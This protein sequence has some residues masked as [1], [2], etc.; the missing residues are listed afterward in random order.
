MS[1]Q[2]LTGV[3]MDRPASARLDRSNM[4]SRSLNLVYVYALATGAIFTFMC[5]WDGIFMSYTGPATFLGFGLMTAA[6]LPIAFLYAELSTML[7]SAGSALVFNTI[8]LNKHMGFW[9]SWL[10]LLCW[11][12]VPTAG[13]LGILDWLVYQ[14]GFSLTP[15]GRIIICAAALAFWCALS[16]FKNVVA[17]KV[18]TFMLLAGIGGI[19]ITAFLYLASGSWSFANFSGF[20]ST[21]LNDTPS[22]Q[23]GIGWICGLAF[24]ITPFFGFETVPALVEEGTFP[25]KDQ[26]KAIL[27]S[28]L[29][30]GAVYVI[31]YFAL[32]GMAPY[33][34]L[35]RGGDCS[36]FI[37]I[38]QI[39]QNYSWGGKFALFLGIVGVLFPIGT[40]VLGFWYS[41]VRMLYAMG[42][43]NFLPKAFSKTNRY[44]QPIL[45]N[46]LIFGISVLF[47][48]M[49]SISDFFNLM[50]FACSACYIV[51]S[52][53]GIVLAKKHPDWKRPYR[54]PGGNVMR[55]LSLVVASVIAVF[56]AIGQSSAGWTGFA[57][58]MGIGFLL[59]LNMILRKWKK[60]PVWMMTPE[61][62]REF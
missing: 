57:L 40:S 8:G 53:S 54:I 43:Q 60:E 58:A 56:C 39:V 37:S 7:P 11:I 15:A 46:I 55:V 35:T 6:V 16:L 5:Y 27:G 50:A 4:L 61:G 12:C 51:T 32:A 33:G 21:C 24:L 34:T 9:S 13:V 62:E 31:F 49:P 28:V 14:F 45:P 59:W 26:K 48:V 2:T 44:S 10:I 20:F 17:G 36:P 19:I 47:L 41:G 42:R 52:I 3:P 23:G 38:Q 29:T 22:Q 25:I 30:C 1:T 18:Q